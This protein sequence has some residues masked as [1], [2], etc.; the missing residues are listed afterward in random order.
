SGLRFSQNRMFGGMKSTTKMTPEM[1]I[2][3]RNSTMRIVTHAFVKWMMA[4]FTRFMPQARIETS[5]TDVTQ[6][7]GSI[8]IARGLTKIESPQKRIT[9]PTDITM[10]SMKQRI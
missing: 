5:T 6:A 1:S 2:K 10:K 4:A 8:G 3:P 7:H 9:V